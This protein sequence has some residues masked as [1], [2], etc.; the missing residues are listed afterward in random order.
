MST[1]KIAQLSKIVFLPTDT[2]SCTKLKLVKLHKLIRSSEDQEIINGTFNKILDVFIH[3]NKYIKS[4]C[5]KIFKDIYYKIKVIDNI[6]IIRM[7]YQY[8]PEINLLILKFI[9]IFY[10]FFI[11]D[12]IVLYYIKKTNIKYSE[13]IINLFESSDI[14]GKSTKLDGLEL[15]MKYLYQGKTEK[16]LNIFNKII[17]C[18]ID[19]RFKVIIKYFINKLTLEKN[20]RF[21]FDLKDYEIDESLICKVNGYTESKLF[22]KL[23]KCYNHYKHIKK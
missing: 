6:K 9:K 19:F 13:E 7:F 21:V 20:K 15:G 14:K 2:Y 10:R 5:I 11:E 8:D 17:N 18:D 23:K 1:K 22:K 4:L 16:C 12:E 3:K